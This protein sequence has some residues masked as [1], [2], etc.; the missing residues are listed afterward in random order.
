M[1]PAKKLA[2]AAS[3]VTK[4][5]EQTV[6]SPSSVQDGD[7]EVLDEDFDAH[8]VAEERTTQHVT[9]DGD[10]DDD[11]DGDDDDDGDDMQKKAVVDEAKKMTSELD[12]APVPSE[13]DQV[14]EYE[15]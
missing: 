8:K 7:P 11:G 13:L 12:N 6:E 2:M 3:K 14:L 1:L 10:D 4:P 15:Y 9:G 5:T